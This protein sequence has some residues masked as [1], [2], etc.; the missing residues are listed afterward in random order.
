[1]RNHFKRWIACLLLAGGACLPSWAATPAMEESGLRLEVDKRQVEVGDTVNVTLEYKRLAS[2]VGGFSSSGGPSIPT[3]D[4]FDVRGTST[5]TRVMMVNNQ[6]SEVST[7]RIRLVATKPGEAT[8]GPAIVIGDDP[9]LGRREVKSNTAVVTVSPKSGFSLFRH[10]KEEAQ[11][12]ASA[13]QAQAPA[14]SPDDLRDIHGLIQPPSFPWGWIVWPLLLATVAAYLIYRRLRRPT[15][16]GIPAK[17][18]GPAEALRERYRALGRSEASGE[19]FCRSASALAR[20]CLQYRY[21]FSAEDFTTSEVLAELK[22]Q[23]AAE[24]VRESV[25]KC[26][27]TCDRILYAEG[28][29]SAAARESTLQALANLLPKA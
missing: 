7:T 26:L 9:K 11:A 2:G 1:M 5:A 27:K 23:K 13:P 15:G 24:A 29:L 18:K 28:V 21:G 19:V 14:A 20:A 22:R 3:L 10:K 8:L 4:N 6:M 17:P 12:P 25:E 16:A